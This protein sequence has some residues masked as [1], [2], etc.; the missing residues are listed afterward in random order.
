LMLSWDLG[1][2]ED[3]EKK[4]LIKAWSA[5]LPELREVRWLSLWSRVPQAL[6]EAACR[7]PQLEALQIKWS[8]I[9]RLDAICAL[10]RLRYLHIGSSTRI[11]SIAPLAA[12][13][14][15]R[16]LDIENFKLVEDF[17][18]LTALTG[19][20]SLS[21]TGSMWSRQDTGSL[22]PFAAMTW[23]RVL[24]LD[25]AFVTSLRPLAALKQLRIL[26]LGGGL[27]MEEYAWLSA[28]LPRTACRWFA[29]YLD[30]SVHGYGACKQCAQK[31]M[32]ML[33][34]KGKGARVIC[35]HCDR[36]R[37]ERHVLAFRSEQER[38]SGV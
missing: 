20:E 9:Q 34:G 23:L 24:E 6:F 11:E 21:V 15:L 33:T 29:P 3:A 25:T 30:M 12:L 27:P 38:A 22:T 36:A 26:G 19:L 16:L 14:E 35:R 28:Q 8:G 5:L 1:A 4:R 31:S 17:T 18:P 10:R 13:G 37:L 32:V 7:M 2:V